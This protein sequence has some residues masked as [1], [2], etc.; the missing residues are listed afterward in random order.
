MKKLVLSL[1]I[2]LFAIT[3]LAQTG[4]KRIA[5]VI[6]NNNYLNAPLKN[7]VN[8][9]NLMESTLKSLGFTVIK[10]VNANRAQ[11]AQAIAEFWKNLGNYNV[12][13]F[14]FAGH[15]VQVNGVN[16]IIPVDASLETQDMVSFEAISVNDVV[17]KFEEYPQNTNIVILDACRNNP[18][19]SWA[20]S[21]ARGFKAMN[22]G[23]GTII[24]FATS[25]GSTA[26]DGEGSNGLF[27]HNL[28]KHIKKPVPIETVFKSTRVDVQK[29]SGGNQSPQEW[30]KLTG[31]FYFAKPTG[32]ISQNLADNNEPEAVVF[33]PGNVEIEYGSISIDTEIGGDLYIDGKKIGF[34]NANSKGNKLNK[35]KT[36]THTVRIEGNETWEKTIT[37]SKDQT[38]YVISKSNKPKDL[39]DQL[40]DSRD[41]KYYKIVKIGNQVWMAEN[42]A[43]NYGSGCW[44]YDNNLSNVTKY[45]YLYNW[46]TAK[47]VCPNGWHLPLKSEFETLLNNVGGAGNAAYNSLK[48][49][50]NSGFSAPLGG[51]RYFNGNFNL[52]REYAY[53]WSSSAYGDADASILYF[54]SYNSGAYMAYYGRSSGFSVRCIQD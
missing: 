35:I 1:F 8:D 36:G 7:P 19:R 27:T 16:Y 46:E 14:F 17:G 2:L 30:T 10:K 23:S 42:L 47:N 21:G 15:G 4:E 32:N 28:V 34:V 37:V 12:A 44:A 25:E 13:L 31:D 49:G 24:A 52:I 20:R 45:G 39:P 40:Y 43:F 48:I 26:A 18:F 51:W 11:M 29:A 41:G 3:V 50:G 33:N 54:Y 53:F 5:L 38:A 22:P 9:A 6:G